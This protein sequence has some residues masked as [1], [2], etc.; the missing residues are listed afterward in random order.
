MKGF[1]RKILFGVPAVGIMVSTG[2]TL[3]SGQIPYSGN[4]TIPIMFLFAF[5]G[6]ISFW[7]FINSREA[8]RRKE[9]NFRRKNKQ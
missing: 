9:E 2:V 5:S 3:L 8:K 6:G 7:L 1:G 4:P